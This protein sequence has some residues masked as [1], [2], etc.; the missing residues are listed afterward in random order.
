MHGANAQ[1]RL[2]RCSGM[3]TK[4]SRTLRMDAVCMGRRPRSVDVA[5]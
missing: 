3:C 4:R 1:R 2:R 5:T